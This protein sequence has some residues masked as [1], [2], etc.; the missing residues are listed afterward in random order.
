MNVINS[1]SSF[2]MNIVDKKY[3]KIDTM[4]KA[5]FVQNNES[6]KELLNEP[7]NVIFPKALE[8]NINPEYILIDLFN[9]LKFIAKVNNT[10]FDNNYKLKSVYEKRKVVVDPL[11]FENSYIEEYL[12][13]YL[14][15][16]TRYI[17]NKK[18]ILFFGYLNTEYKL[19]DN[20]LIKLAGE[21]ITIVKALNKF[22]DKEK[23]LI[24][25][26]I[27]PDITILNINK[28]VYIT[29]FKQRKFDVLN[30]D[31]L[32]INFKN[33]T[34]SIFNNEKNFSSL[35]TI[36]YIFEKAKFFNSD[37]LIVI[38]A[39]FAKDEAKYNYI[40][41][42]KAI[43]A[44]KLF[45]LDDYGS[46]GTYYLGLDGNF[47][48]ESSVISLITNIMSKKQ[49]KFQNVIACGSSKGG[50]A[51]LYYGFKYNFGNIIVGAP[52]YR[53]GTYL[54]NLSIKDY[55]YEI[56]GDIKCENSLR[57][58]NLIRLVSN[59]NTKVHLLTGQG[60][61]QY[62]LYLKDFIQL[63][64]D[65]ELNLTVDMIEINGHNDIA[66]EFPVY[67]NTHLAGILKGYNFTN[68]VKFINKFRT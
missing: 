59:R 10:F 2:L 44:N 22:L 51:A 50:S 39:A 27:I 57:Y 4:H 45:I 13:I 15:N 35:A 3:I 47:R 64:S 20:S 63:A 55:A 1:L 65:Y 5:I 9:D 43:D 62:K 41:S 68:I 53:I 60:D 32:N 16:L 30:K 52:Q 33:I 21:E 28:E 56:F 23:N 31:I 8:L 11:T 18:I 48:V 26:K 24:I 61:R 37:S 19:I 17:H 46:K 7:N 29:D 54:C 49:I 67:L 14:N 66:K 40:K 36:R 25:K 42:L 38:F 12:L 34:K 6:I 58:D